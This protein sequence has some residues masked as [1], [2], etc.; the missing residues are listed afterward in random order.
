MKRTFRYHLT[1]L[2]FPLLSLLLVAYFGYHL[3]EGEHGLRARQV[4]EK[5]LS[6]AQA[7][8]SEKT[9][10]KEALEHRVDLMRS[11]HLDPD[12]LEERVRV[13]LNHAD[14]D[15]VVV[16]YDMDDEGPGAVSQQ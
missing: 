7:I 5:Q 14:P 8:L 4:L 6:T 16:I 13:M 9:A 12:L 2:W 11:D 10:A 3:V 1:R 15:E